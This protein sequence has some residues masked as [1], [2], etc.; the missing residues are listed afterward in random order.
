MALNSSLNYT[1]NEV[2]RNSNSSMGASVGASKKL[3]KDKLNTNLGVLYNNSQGDMNSSSVFGV[4]FNNSYV[5]LQK[6]NFNMSIISMFRSSTASKKYNDLNATLNYSYTIDKIKLPAKKEAKKEDK[7]VSDPI[8]KISHKDK[9]YEG[10]RNQIIKQ[11][12]DL[13]LALRPIPK[14]DAAELEH[15][16]T[17]AT[18]TPDDESFK[19]KALNYLKAYDS[20]NDILDKYNQYMLET[21][22][23]LEAEMIRKD[24]GFE[25]A[26][27]L[28]LGRVNKHPLHGVDAKD[29]TNKASYNSYLKLVERKDK[30]LQPLLVHRWMLKEITT[31]ANTSPAEIHL[32]EN[33]SVFNKEELMPFFKMMKDKKTDAEVI[34]EL[35]IKLIPF[36]HDLALKNVKDDEVEFKHLKIN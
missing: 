20:N 9:T 3:L 10:T 5:L 8:L 28:A 21:V 24:E 1:S 6:H 30:K 17:L 36:Y 32:N 11:L 33:L 19:E 2:G 4:K 22:K 16:L 34:E 31:L 14:E 35:K 25:N 18:L 27:V 26:Y 23:S 15:L 29:I 13:Q 12:Q 7:I